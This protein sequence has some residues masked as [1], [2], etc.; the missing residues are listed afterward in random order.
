[1]VF[2][3]LKEELT[4]TP[5]IYAPDQSLESTIGTHMYVFDYAKG[6]FLNWKVNKYPDVILGQN[7]GGKAGVN[8]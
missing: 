6:A 7:L 2:E 1:M 4:S 3:F 8:L 5:I